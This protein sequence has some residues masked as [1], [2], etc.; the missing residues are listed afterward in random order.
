ML[1]LN[2]RE[3]ASAIWLVI[4]VV[5]SLIKIPAIRGNVLGLFKHAFHP[6]LATPFLLMA[7]YVTVIVWLLARVGFWTPPLLKATVIWFLFS[8][9]VVAFNAIGERALSVSVGKLVRDN[10]KV[11]VLL[12]FLVGTYVFPLWAEFIFIVPVATVVAMLDAVAKGYEEFENVA[13]LTTGVQ[14]IVGLVILSGAVIQ[15]VNEAQAVAS[16]ASFRELLLPPILSVIFVPC[17]VG[18]VVYARYEL[19]MIRVGLGRDLPFGVKF[20]AV[21]QFVL[22]CGFDTTKIR[23]L[24]QKHAVVLQ[25]IST[26]EDV[27]SFVEAHC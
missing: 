25:R 20:Y 9:V 12:E 23:N 5:I 16:L 6:K 7:V 3:L 14:A 22:S 1:S 8:G 10:L 13:K 15:A 24:L 21:W 17:V 27:D 26:K 11:I 4:L 18:L 19:L 2:D